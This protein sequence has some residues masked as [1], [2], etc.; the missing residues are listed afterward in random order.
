VARVGKQHCFRLA[1]DVQF[2]EE[3]LNAAR[4]SMPRRSVVQRKRPREDMFKDG[5]TAARSL[6]PPPAPLIHVN[7]RRSSAGTRGSGRR[8]DDAAHCTGE[9]K[10]V[11][12][13][14]PGCQ[15]V[16]RDMQPAALS[17]Q[18]NDSNW[19]RRPT[20]PVHPREMYF[21]T[22]ARQT[23]PVN[24]RNFSHKK[25]SLPDSR[26]IVIDRRPVTRRTTPT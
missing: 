18:P 13:G 1:P 4:Y 12:S 3:S 22:I 25:M 14:L 24:T 11:P 9:G 2:L 16:T 8:P 26:E 17:K 5:Q 21:E 19:Q 23:S 6:H 7:V 20:C 10:P 15:S